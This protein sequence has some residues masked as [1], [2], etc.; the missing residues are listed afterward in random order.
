MLSVQT[1]TDGTHRKRLG[2]EHQQEI[3]LVP[4]YYYSMNDLK[5][6]VLIM[7]QA[8]NGAKCVPRLFDVCIAIAQFETDQNADTETS[9]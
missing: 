4:N 8:Y 1:V 9:K 5:N 2:L 6:T 7:E 3:S